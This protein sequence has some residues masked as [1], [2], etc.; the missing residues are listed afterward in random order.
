[1]RKIT[2]VKNRGLLP[3]KLQSSAE[4]V[5]A[6]PMQIHKTALALVEWRGKEWPNPHCRFESRQVCPEEQNQKKR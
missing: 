5:A 6:R 3:Q 2:G 1:M 4:T